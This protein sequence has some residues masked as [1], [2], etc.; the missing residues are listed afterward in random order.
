M[1]KNCQLFSKY[2]QWCVLTKYVQG[3]DDW[4]GGVVWLTTSDEFEL[5][6]PEP[7]QV[8]RV[9]RQVELSGAFSLVE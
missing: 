5:K 8:E 1:W 2:I 7:S 9:P 4:A 3:T 6:F